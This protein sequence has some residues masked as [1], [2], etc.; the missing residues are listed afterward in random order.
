MDGNEFPKLMKTLCIM[1]VIVAILGIIAIVA[2]NSNDN[3]DL[4][5]YQTKWHTVAEDETL[6]E[7]GTYCKAEDDDVRDWIKAVKDLNNMT[8][9]GLIAGDYIKIYISK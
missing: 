2:T 6:W 5:D 7:L 8:G 3:F 9:S 1:L 4:A